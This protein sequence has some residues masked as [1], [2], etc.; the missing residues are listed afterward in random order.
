MPA[1]PVHRSFRKVHS[2]TTAASINVSHS[3][4]ACK[5]FKGENAAGKVQHE[6]DKDSKTT[7]KQTLDRKVSV[8]TVL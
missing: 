8:L 3:L 1:H 2:Y 5:I 4:F 7:K 6:P